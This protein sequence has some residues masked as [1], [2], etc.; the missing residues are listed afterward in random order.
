MNDTCICPNCHTELDVIEYGHGLKCSEC[1]CK[2]DVFPDTTLY[3]ETVFGVVG[4][5]VPK[6]D[7]VFHALLENLGN[8]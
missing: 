3:L 8:A 7:G 1:G 2:I 6:G 5:S 4:I